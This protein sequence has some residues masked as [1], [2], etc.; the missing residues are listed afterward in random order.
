MI[1]SY[2]AASLPDAR[3]IAASTLSFGMLNARLFWIARRNAGFELGSLPPALT[4]M[5]MSFETRANCLAMRSQRA[6]IVCLRTSNMRPIRARILAES[7]VGR[8]LLRGGSVPDRDAD[9]A[10]VDVAGLVQIPVIAA[11]AARLDELRKDG[12]IVA[13]HF[14]VRTLG[15]RHFGGEADRLD[16]HALLGLLVHA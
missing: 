5:L 4:A 9:F 1:V 10:D 14:Q 12:S 16:R 3:L 8:P 2:A 7:G 15:L 6:N 11:V 13:Q